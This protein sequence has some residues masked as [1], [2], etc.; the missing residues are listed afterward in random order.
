[1]KDKFWQSYDSGLADFQ[2]LS[3]CSDCKFSDPDNLGLGFPCCT[4]PGTISKDIEGRCLMKN[5]MYF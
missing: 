3:N 2:V 4:Y 5:L 1:M